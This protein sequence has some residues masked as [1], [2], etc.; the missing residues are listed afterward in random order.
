MEQGVRTKSY[1]NSTV[2]S[3]DQNAVYLFDPLGAKEQSSSKFIIKKIIKP[4]LLCRYASIEFC[5][6]V[7]KWSWVENHPG[8]SEVV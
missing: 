5:V 2:E 7:V 3:K 6:S 8:A 4:S 1:T